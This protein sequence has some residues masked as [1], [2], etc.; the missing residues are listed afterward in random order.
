M[1][2]SDLEAVNGEEGLSLVRQ[3]VNHP[4]H[5]VLTDVVMPGISGRQMVDQIWSW[6]PDI[7]VLYMSGYTEEAIDHHGFSETKAAFLQK[8]FTPEALARKVREVLDT[9][10][11]DGSIKI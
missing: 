6:R 8:P 3:E 2:S 5:L 4:I 11:D 9:G 7:K 10:E 1:C